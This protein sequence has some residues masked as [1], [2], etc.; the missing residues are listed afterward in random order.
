[1]KRGNYKPKVKNENALKSYLNKV[2]NERIKRYNA[3]T[4]SK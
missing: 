1:M 2:K 3:G 4:I